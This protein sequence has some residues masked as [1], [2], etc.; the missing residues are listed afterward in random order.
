MRMNAAVK[1]KRNV[2]GVHVLYYFFDLVSFFI[3]GKAKFR[4]R[5]VYNRQ[6]M[7]GNEKRN[8]S[9]FFLFDDSLEEKSKIHLIKLE[10]RTF[11]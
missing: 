5:Q 7:N 11:L 9:A 1:R 8:S 6:I 4:K 3:D 10:N 2:K